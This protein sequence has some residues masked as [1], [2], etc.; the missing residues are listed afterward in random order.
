M[1]NK[2]CN[3]L[4]YSSCRFK[5]G[6]SL[7]NLLDT[8]LWR[9]FKGLG[10]FYTT[11]SLEK[12]H[13]TLKIEPPKT[14]HTLLINPTP[15]T[16]FVPSSPHVLRVWVPGRAIPSP[17]APRVPGLCPGHTQVLGTGSACLCQADK[18]PKQTTTQ[19][20]A[21]LLPHA[22]HE[23]FPM[24]DCSV[25]ELF[26]GTAGQAE[27]LWTQWGNNMHARRKRVIVERI[28]FFF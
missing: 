1:L 24:Q 5:W 16:T 7:R 10:Y 2:I 4:N 23:E 27:E 13:A 14:A 11:V 18:P 28:N 22:T 3:I 6:L 26:L 19:R 12:G 20:Q 8:G 17:K 21:C 15:M 9:L 25:L